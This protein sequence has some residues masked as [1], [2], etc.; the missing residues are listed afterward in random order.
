MKVFKRILKYFL[1]VL[2]LLVVA[3]VS[4]FFVGLLYPYRP[5]DEKIAEAFQF[6]RQNGLND[7]FAVFVDFGLPSGLP[8]YMVYDFKEKEV[9]YRCMCASGLAKDRYSNQPGSHLSSLGK[10][11][12]TNELYRMSIGIDGIVVDGLETSNSNAR[13][14]KILIHYSKVLNRMPKSIFPL[15]II[16]K[17]ISWGCFCINEEGVKKTQSL[18]K[19]MLLWVYQ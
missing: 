13:N 16:G 17:N 8:R 18:N 6:C 19:P 7:Q 10:Y 11:R 12:I 4:M 1:W 2:L 14:R 3:F 5:S 15:P 9:V